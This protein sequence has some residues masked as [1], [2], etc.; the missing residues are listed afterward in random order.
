MSLTAGHF[1]ASRKK[2]FSGFRNLSPVF[3][4]TGRKQTALSQR[5]FHKVLNYPLYTATQLFLQTFL[6]QVFGNCWVK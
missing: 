5:R 4:F 6:M 3:S 1:W 2:L